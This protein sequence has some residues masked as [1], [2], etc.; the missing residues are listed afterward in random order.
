MRYKIADLKPA[1]PGNVYAL[2]KEFDALFCT[3]DGLDKSELW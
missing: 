1:K 3:I 2:T